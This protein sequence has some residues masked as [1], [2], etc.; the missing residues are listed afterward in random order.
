M[1]LQEELPERDR[2]R[3]GYTEQQK[4]EAR[5]RIQNKTIAYGILARADRARYGKLIEEVEN[6][7]LKGHDDYPKNPTEANNLLV[8]YRNYIT[9]NKRTNVQGGLD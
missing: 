6:D 7:F 4:R 8:N 5:E 3:N 2:P 9:V 1:H